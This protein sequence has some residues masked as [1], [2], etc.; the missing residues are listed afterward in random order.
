MKI[1]YFSNDFILTLQ[2]FHTIEKSV[3]IN[4]K[5]YMI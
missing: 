5:K 3:Q 1:S 4:Y 2:R